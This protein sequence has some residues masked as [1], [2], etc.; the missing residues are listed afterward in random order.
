[1]DTEQSK[2]ATPEEILEEILRETDP[3]GCDNDW[4]YAPQVEGILSHP[5]FPEFQ[6][7]IMSGRTVPAAYATTVQ[8][9]DSMSGP[10]DYAEAARTLEDH[11]KE[12]PHL[13][14]MKK[15]FA[16]MASAKLKVLGV[17]EG[18]LREHGLPI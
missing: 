2:N 4:S 3:E 1:M 12:S 11:L 13:S 18:E 8:A 5:R 15:M 17:T 6:R 16:H 14:E 7:K 9:V 10:A